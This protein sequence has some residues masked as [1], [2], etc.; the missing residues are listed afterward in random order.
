MRPLLKSGQVVPTLPCK[1]FRRGD[2]VFYKKNGKLF[3]HRIIKLLEKGVV[4]TDDC[5]ITDYIYIPYQ[6]IFGIYPTILRGFIGFVY[7][8]LIRNL[9]I[10]FRRIKKIYLKKFFGN[11][12]VA[13]I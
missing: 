12:R 7:H 13:E 9:Y 6:D 1:T 5:G 11:T 10:C 8:I 3:L 4:V 2:I